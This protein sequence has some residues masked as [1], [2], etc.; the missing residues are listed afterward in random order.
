V[1]DPNISIRKTL[2]NEG[3]YSDNSADHGGPTNFGIASASHPGLD[4]KNLTEEQAIQIYKEQYWKVYYSQIDSQDLADKIF[5]VGVLFGVGRAVKFL[6]F[7]LGVSVDGAFGPNTLAELNSSDA[8]KV[9]SDYKVTLVEHAMQIGAND[10]T[11]RQFVSGWVRR[12][13]S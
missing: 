2:V 7:V 1:A 5:D 9:L 8:N 10:P 13:N 6:Q 11:Q 3:G 12:I 4:I